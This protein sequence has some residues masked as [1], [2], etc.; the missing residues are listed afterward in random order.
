MHLTM[1]SIYEAMQK[2]QLSSGT[3]NMGL[4]ILINEDNQDESPTP[5]AASLVSL[6]HKDLAFEVKEAVPKL[7]FGVFFRDFQGEKI[8][9]QR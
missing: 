6:K 7:F 9:S 3:K 2:L 1:K 8:S 4:I 5:S